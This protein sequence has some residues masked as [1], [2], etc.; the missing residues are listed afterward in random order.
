VFYALAVKDINEFDR[1]IDKL[2]F[3]KD[4]RASNNYYQLEAIKLL[5]LLSSNK[6][7]DFYTKLEGLTEEE[8]KNTFIAYV[9]SLN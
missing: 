7:E 4:L 8:L 2:K 5:R 6:I 9:I 1:A 3:F